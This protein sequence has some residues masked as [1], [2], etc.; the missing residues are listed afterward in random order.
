MTR[1]TYRERM[2]LTAA[3]DSA[4][5]ALFTTEQ[6]QACKCAAC[7]RVNVA[8]ATV[9]WSNERRPTDTTLSRLRAVTQ[10][11]LQPCRPPVGGFFYRR[12]ATRS[13]ASA[14]DAEQVSRRYVYF[15]QTV[16]K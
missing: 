8:R 7:V 12:S 16:N 10:P 4:E 11:S 5:R 9:E 14:S 6:N 1:H 15:I 2:E 13:R 3:V